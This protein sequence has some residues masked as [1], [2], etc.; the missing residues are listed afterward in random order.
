M[1]TYTYDPGLRITTATG[2][3]GNTTFFEYDNVGRLTLKKDYN[4]NV[5][6]KY[7]YH[8]KQ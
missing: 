5:L 3:N 1:T 4:R 7:T 8:Y 6:N 2:H